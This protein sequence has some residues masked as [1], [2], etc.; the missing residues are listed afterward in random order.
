[1]AAAATAAAAAAAASAA[2]TAAA[3]A[4]AMRS[5][6]HTR[7]HPELPLLAADGERS[8]RDDRLLDEPR[9]GLAHGHVG[10]GRLR[11]GLD[12]AGRH[13]FLRL[14]GHGELP[15]PLRVP[16]ADDGHCQRG[17]RGP[18][19]AT[20]TPSAATPSASASATTATASRTTTD[21]LPRAAGER[22]DAL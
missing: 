1:P 19:S 12:R 15:V 5:R 18:A 13:L 16:C 21:S 7:R 3:A 8:G 14:H 10:H 17:S 2:S 6:R 4:A 20:T 9:H 11:L 22:D